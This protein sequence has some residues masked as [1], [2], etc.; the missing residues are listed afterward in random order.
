MSANHLINYLQQPHIAEIFHTMIITLTSIS[1]RWTLVRGII[2]TLWFTIVERK[3]ENFLLETTMR[4]LKLN[5]IDTWG[6]EDHHLFVACDYPNYA[7]SSNNGRELNAIGD[8]LASYAQL[9]INK[10]DRQ[11]N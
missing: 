9:D 2:R 8:L 5:A 3:L 1:Y 11:P 7:A 6:R 10:D 4:L